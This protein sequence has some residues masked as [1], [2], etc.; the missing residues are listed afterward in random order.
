MQK[1]MSRHL[2]VFLV[3]VCLLI[4][5]PA[6]SQESKPSGMPRTD[7]ENDVRSLISAL[8]PNS[9]LRTMLEYGARGEGVRYGWMN[10]MRRFGINQA[11]IEV[12]LTWFFGP[13]FQ[14]AVRIMYFAAYERAG[15]Q[16]TDENILHAIQNSG[17]EERLKVE[18][19]KFVSGGFWFE[20]P[21]YFFF[22]V[23]SATEIT[24][25]D[26]EWLPKLP[27]MFR[28]DDTS[29]SPLIQAVFAQDEADVARLV[30][31]KSLNTQDLDHAL[32]MSS[33][34]EPPNILR[35]LIRA[36]A[37]VN[38]KN[39]DGDK[40]TPLHGAVWTHHLKNVEVLIEAGAN[41]NARD[42]WGETPLTTALNSKMD[43]GETVPLL[44]KAGADVNAANQFGLTALMRA[45]F[46]QPASVIELLIQRGANVNA[47]DH[48]GRTALMFA[49]DY[50]SI[51][52]VRVLLA[53]SASIESRDQGGNT[54]LSNAKRTGQK[55]IVQLLESA[56][57]KK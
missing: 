16:I 27:H 29:R 44:L 18:A 10:E 6:H 31:T 32:L 13:R 2:F 8:P 35:L 5:H 26:K 7:V 54:A 12:Q 22:P 43:Q 11:V 53:A 25:F 57:A 19:L 36:G 41:V 49:V 24:L 34:S 42:K 47:R 38:A 30:N 4:I 9:G 55:E 39:D 50:G 40:G 1:E 15:S 3:A 33:W 46:A 52:A 14:K 51:A 45:T 23:N 17:L 56:R 37:N 48:R 21:S 20:A 28:I